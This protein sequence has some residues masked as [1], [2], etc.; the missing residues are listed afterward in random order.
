[1]G[2]KE[3]NLEMFKYANLGVLRMAGLKKAMVVIPLPKELETEKLEIERKLCKIVE[4]EAK[5]KMLVNFFDELMKG[6]KQLSEGEVI[7]FSKKFKKAG[8]KLI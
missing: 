6:A 3:V 4:L 8:S 2:W 1:M 5:K 7:E